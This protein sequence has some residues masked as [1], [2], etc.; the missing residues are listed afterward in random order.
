MPVKLILIILLAVFVSAFTG[1]NLENKCSLW[2]FHT[3]KD[4]PVVALVIGSFVAG[5]LV[6]LPVFFVSKK[7]K[8]HDK[9]IIKK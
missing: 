2:F 1:F 9:D 3:F 8:N 5:V 7:K 6:T 4:L